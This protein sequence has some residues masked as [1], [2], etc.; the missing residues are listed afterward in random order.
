MNN[1]KRYFKFPLLFL[2]FAA[3]ACF[4]LTACGESAEKEDDADHTGH[5]FDITFVNESDREI[6]TLDLDFYDADDGRF[7]MASI[8]APHHDSE[9]IPPMEKGTVYTNPFSCSTLPIIHDLPQDSVSI[10]FG[11]D[12][13]D[14]ATHTYAVSE[15]WGGQIQCVYTEDAGLTVTFVSADA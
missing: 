12:G 2:A 13:E 1:S 7:A 8:T 11:L 9:H 5:S 4:A 15:L 6:T 10:Q 3:F 14:V